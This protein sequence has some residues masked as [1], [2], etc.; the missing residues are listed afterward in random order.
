MAHQGW[1][2]ATIDMQHGAIGFDAAYNMLIAISTTDTTPIV[3]VPSNDAGLIG[4]VLDAGAFGVMCP[5]VESRA[6]AEAFAA[7]C[8]YAPRGRRSVGPIRAGY[9]AG[10]DYVAHANDTIVTFA[11]IETAQGLAHVDAIARTC[12]IDILFVGPSDLGLSLGRAPKPDQDDTV[13]VEAIDHI[14][15]A[16][17][18][19]GIRAGIYCASVPYAQAMTAKGFDFVTVV[20]DEGLL[21]G[22]RALRSHFP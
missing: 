16:A 5:T 4:R 11:Q 2:S 1:D 19:A 7:A 21:A 12:G 13:V 8:R 3:R 10:S 6:D 15:Q 22:G 9:Y 18:T 20:S 14:L 17:H